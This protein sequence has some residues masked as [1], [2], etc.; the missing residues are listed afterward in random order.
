MLSLSDN[1]GRVDVARG[2]GGMSGAGVLGRRER[3]IYK[4]LVHFQVSL[5]RC[6]VLLGHWQ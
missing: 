1:R 4:V 5:L 3:I 2:E 6:N